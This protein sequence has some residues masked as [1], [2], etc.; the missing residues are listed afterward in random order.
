[1]YTQNKKRIGLFVLA[2][3]L[4]F[5]WSTVLADDLTPPPYRGNPLSVHAEWQFLPGTT[6]LSLTQFNWVDDNDPA[7]NLSGVPISNP[8]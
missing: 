2:A 3:V 6:F 5:S 4:M 7:T 8:V 1:M